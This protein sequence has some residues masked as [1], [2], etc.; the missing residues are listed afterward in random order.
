[1][2]GDRW[3]RFANLRAYYGFMF[4]HPGK[5]PLFM[6]SEFG[7]EHEWSHDHSLD[8]HLVH[9]PGHAGI[10]TLIRDLNHLYEA[11]LP[12]TSSIATAPVSN[13]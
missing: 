8:W 1:M 13:G 11:C 5:K 4:G 3:Q 7:Q 10:Q 12:C 6:G 9:E 2:P